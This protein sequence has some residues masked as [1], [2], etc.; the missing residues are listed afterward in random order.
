MKDGARD[1]HENRITAQDRNGR[2]ENTRPIRAGKAPAQKSGAP[3]AKRPEGGKVRSL[4]PDASE[5]VRVRTGP[6][7]IMMILILVLLSL[8]TIMVF[9]ASYPYANSHYGDSFYYIKRQ[10]VFVAIGIVAMIVVMRLPYT[11]FKK[12]ALPA[13]GVTLLLLAL[14]PI[15]GLSQ[16]VA[17]RWIGVP[18]T[19][20]TFQP[21]EVMKLSLVLVLAWY[22]DRHHKQMNDP[23]DRRNTIVYG[24]LWPAMYIGLACGLVLIEKHLSGTLI[25]GMIGLMVLFIG[26]AHPGWMAL[27]YGGVGGAAAGIYLLLNP[28]AL[29]RITTFLNPNAD[30][31]KEDWQTTQGLFAIGSGGFLGLGLGNSRQKYSYVSQ[32]QNDFIFTIWCEETGFVG[33]V[34][35]IG[36]FIAF[37]WRGFRIAMKAPDTF[38]AIVAYGIVGKVGLQALLNIAVVTDSIPNTGISLPFFSYGGSSLVILMVE[39]GVL[40][41]ISRHSYQRK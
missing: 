15:I 17:K 33:A 9:S 13:Y 37:I 34:L 30:A 4:V 18:G 20:L 39:M 21:S 31:L 12:F 26:G 14:V 29:S 38:S 35:L 36:L 22:I 10:L 3:L 19:P 16:G 23:M 28:Y 27:L 1:A 5:I 8:G 2:R 24:I 32:P 7:R 41:S 6:D 25:L 11:M 40:L